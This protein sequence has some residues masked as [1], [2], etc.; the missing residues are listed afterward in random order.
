MILYATIAEISIHPFSLTFPIQGHL[1]QLSLRQDAPWTSR[2]SIADS[3][4]ICL[5]NAGVGLV[6]QKIVIFMNSLKAF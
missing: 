4:N 5:I 1:S 2:Q 3:W 6:T